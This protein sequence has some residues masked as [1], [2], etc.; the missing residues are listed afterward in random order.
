M[1]YLRTH[2]S[3]EPTTSDWLKWA[4]QARTQSNPDPLQRLLLRSL[5]D[6]DY[7]DDLWLDAWYYKPFAGGKTETFAM[8][9]SLYHFTN[10]TRP[11]R[12]WR[13]DGYAYRNTQALGNDAFLGMYGLDVRFDLSKPLQKYVSFATQTAM[14][15]MTLPPSYLLAMEAFENA[16]HSETSA[17]SHR[18]VWKK[19]LSYADAYVFTSTFVRQ[20]AYEELERLPA[21]LQDL[22]TAMHMAQ[23]LAM[24]HH[25]QGIGGLCHSEFEQLVDEILC[26]SRGK[27]D[28]SPY[29]TGLFDDTEIPNC[30]QLYDVA[31]IEK[32][33]ANDPIFNTHS[34]LS[35]EDRL[36][37]LAKRSAEWRI[38]PQDSREPNGLKLLFDDQAIFSGSCQDMQ[39]SPAVLLIAKHQYELATAAT[40]MIIE[41]AAHEHATQ[42]RNVASLIEQCKLDARDQKCS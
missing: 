25:A 7:Q 30:Q 6:A 23:D 35:F 15:D 37:E 20:F 26:S 9:T 29:E 10:V 12:Y 19:E 33:I 16:T 34:S 3:Q 32:L 38:K 22:G 17:Q 21:R 1:S 36:I 42:L 18:E 39:G 14:A 2:V 8:L 11:G 24:P 28:S 31:A 40:V 13:Y 5:V 41:L 27:V 4:D